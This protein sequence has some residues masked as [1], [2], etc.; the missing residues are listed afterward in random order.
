M[1]CWATVSI[2]AT[3]YIH[4]AAALFVVTQQAA[5][6]PPRD[7]QRG[8]EMIRRYFEL[9]TGRLRDGWLDGI[10]TREQWEDARP[11]AVP[12]RLGRKLLVLGHS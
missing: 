5:A 1:H 3:V 9:E 4:F 2:R 6:Q 12:D 7:T 10:Q 11:E 8:D